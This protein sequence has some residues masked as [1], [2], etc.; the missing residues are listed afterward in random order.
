MIR[1]IL[2]MRSTLKMG[3]MIGDDEL[4]HGKDKRL[5][6]DF[7]TPYIPNKKV[8]RTVLKILEIFQ[9]RSL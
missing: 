1:M 3:S 4:V 5:E 2:V 7:V 6:M 8:Q 9:G